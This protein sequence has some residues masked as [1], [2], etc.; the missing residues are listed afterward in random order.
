M[1]LDRT[2][3]RRHGQRALRVVRSP[4]RQQHQQ[5]LSETPQ[6]EPELVLP[7]APPAATESAATALETATSPYHDAEQGTEPRGPE[8]PAA[9]TPQDTPAPPPLASFATT[10]RLLLAHA[11][12]ARHLLSH[13]STVEALTRPRRREMLEEIERMKRT[14]RALQDEIHATTS[15]AE[16]MESLVVHL[17]RI[18]SGLRDPGDGPDAAPGSAGEPEELQRRQ[19]RG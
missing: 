3:R 4:T 15:N 1:L 18:T 13:R 16:A 5:L 6:A 7:A 17:Q 14:M 8:A 9:S 12:R 2:R 10:Q 11:Q 19:Q